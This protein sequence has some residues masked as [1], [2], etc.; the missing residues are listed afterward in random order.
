MRQV[1]NPLN[2]IYRCCLFIISVLLLTQC[3]EVKYEG[4]WSLIIN[5]PDGSEVFV[6]YLPTDLSKPFSL[7]K[8]VED[9]SVELKSEPKDHYTVFEASVSSDSEQKVFLSLRGETDDINNVLYNFNGKVD[10]AEIYRQSPHDVNAWIVETIAMQA[11]P[12]VALKRDSIFSVAISDAPFHYNNFTSQAFYPKRGMVA[13]SSGDN[14]ETPG[15]Q[16]DTSQVLNLDYNA[17]KTQIFTPGKVLPYYH[18][19]SSTQTHTFSGIIFDTKATSLKTL[20]KEVI[21]NA[22]DHFS[23]GAYTDYFGALA[24]TTPYFNL[25]KNET[26]KSEYWVIPAVEYGNTQYGRDAFW[27]SMMLDPEYST[28]ALESEMAVVNHFAEY[29]LFAIIWAYRAHLSGLKVNF[30]Q[31]QNYVN[32]V[33]KRVTDNAYYSYYEGDGRLDFQYWGDLMAFEK[34]DIIAYNQGLFA[35]AIQ[36]AEN[37]GLS[38]KTNPLVAK[39]VYQ[40]LYNEELGF[41][42]VSKFKSILSP[43]AIIPDLLAQLYLNETFLSDGQVQRH[44]NRMTK[45]AKTDFGFKIVSTPEGQYLP[46][47]AYDIP[48]YK[49]QVSR[50]TWVDGEY[51]RGG[52]YF[53]YDNLFL[54]TA[55]LHQVEGA[56]E[57]LKWRVALDFKIGSTTY[58]HLNTLTGEAKKP[59]M[60]WNVAVY[61]IWRKLVDEQKADDELFT[62]VDDIVRTNQKTE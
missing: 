23:S 50:G 14:A 54:I 61:A 13:L 26:G 36:I 24:F 16:P 6:A 56:E 7:N 51:F 18:P 31:V 30:E 21:L 28:S 40:S 8:Q 34:N 10:S 38:I 58:E 41:L 27:I 44:Y 55:Y 4:T 3:K 60:G 42:P 20:R 25:R 1:S 32:A 45:Y 5:Q 59:N 9:Y 11:I 57:L 15:I 2:I 29:P 48:S 49:S 12:M 62:L 17:E 35:V 19:I 33:E 37:L 43:D 46:L 52:S 47:E 53:L 39:K 22:A